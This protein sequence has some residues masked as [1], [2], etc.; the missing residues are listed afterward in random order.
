MQVV[1]PPVCRQKLA[2]LP[3]DPCTPRCLAGGHLRFWRRGYRTWPRVCH[4]GAGKHRWST[5]PL[6]KIGRSPVPQASFPYYPYYSAKQCQISVFHCFT[7]ASTG[8]LSDQS[9]ADRETNNSEKIA[10]FKLSKA[11]KPS[12]GQKVP[13]TR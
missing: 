1:K 4:T 8:C 5:S 13:F 10:W 7:L 2:C 12:K 3:M 11:V 6:T 9:I